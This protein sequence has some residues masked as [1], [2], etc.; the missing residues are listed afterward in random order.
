LSWGQ[1][2]RELERLAEAC[3]VE[4]SAR[5]SED[6]WIWSWVRIGIRD[7]LCLSN[8]RVIVVESGQ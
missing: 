7:N 4:V 3:D 8:L 2:Q 1:K 5:E 6:A